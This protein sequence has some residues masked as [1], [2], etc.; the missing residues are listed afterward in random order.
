MKIIGN[1]WDDV[2]GAEF[3]KEYYQK[4]RHFLDGEYSNKTIYPL[5][6]YIYTALKL[7]SYSD[8]KVVILGQDPYHE[9]NQAHGLAFSVNKGV[10]VPPSLQNIYKELHDDLGCSIPNHG[11]LISWARQGVLLLNTV[12]TVQAH[13]AN[14]HRGKGWEELTD[15][16]IKKVNEK[17]EPVVFILWG[18]NARS[19]KQFITNNK[20]LIL[21]SVHP[22]PLSAFNGF[23]GSR[24]FS[25]TNQFLIDNNL[26]PIDWQIR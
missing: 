25:K 14:S 17:D 18:S 21:E 13:R 26:K 24:P 4:L 23:F 5:P 20:H 1:D 19:K 22:S 12:L 7:T 8:T 6:Q 10:P 9:P 15:T 11:F 2:L 3:D 16:I